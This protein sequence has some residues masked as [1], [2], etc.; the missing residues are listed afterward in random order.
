LEEK[1]PDDVKAKESLYSQLR[2]DD[3]F[4]NLKQACDLWT[5]AFFL[6]LLKED[7]LHFDRVPTT[8]TLR[9]YRANGTV[10]GN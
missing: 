1:T 10:H 4:W 8:G 9:Q 7:V 5:A 6:P 2:R 3:N